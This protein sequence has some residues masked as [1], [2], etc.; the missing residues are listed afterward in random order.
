MRSKRTYFFV[1]MLMLFF[2]AIGTGLLIQKANFGT[3]TSILLSA[4]IIALAM[5]V[6][7]LKDE[8]WGFKGIGLIVAPLASF[9]LL[10][11]HNIRHVKDL[12][13]LEEKLLVGS[14]LGLVVFGVVALVMIAEEVDFRVHMW[15]KKRARDRGGGK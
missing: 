3:S 1:T 2:G 11:L 12:H 15:R 13:E 9:A 8:V 7:V 4:F 6:F 5:G 10:A 14:I